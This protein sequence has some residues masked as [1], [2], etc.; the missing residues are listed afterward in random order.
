M[1]VTG[2]IEVTGDR[3]AVRWDAPPGPRIFVISDTEKIKRILVS[4]FAEG[5]YGKAPMA[6]EQYHDL[7]G[8]SIFGSNGD[9]WLA[10]R[11]FVKPLFTPDHLRASIPVFDKYIC[12][13]IA[14]VDGQSS[15]TS[16][17]VQDLMSRFTMAAFGAIGF[18]AQLD[19][20]EHADNQFGKSLDYVQTAM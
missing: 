5:V 4:G 17:D 10:K 1:I 18:G 9:A 19:C 16:V 15:R 12:D 6:L 8:T 14:H 7:F 11:E 3:C 13:L 20:I 2:V